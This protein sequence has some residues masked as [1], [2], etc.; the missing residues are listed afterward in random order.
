MLTSKRKTPDTALITYRAVI[1]I[2]GRC[3]DLYIFS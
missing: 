1:E 2:A 3:T